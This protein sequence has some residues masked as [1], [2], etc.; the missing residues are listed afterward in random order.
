MIAEKG[1]EEGM[2]SLIL[3]GGIKGWAIAGT[4]YQELMVE[5]ERGVWEG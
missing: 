3:G 5:Y 4:E 1:G 2:E